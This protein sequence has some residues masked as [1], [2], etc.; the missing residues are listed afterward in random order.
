MHLLGVNWICW[1]RWLLERLSEDHH[2]SIEA[3]TYVSAFKDPV[4]LSVFVYLCQVQGPLQHK[5]YL[6]LPGSRNA[7]RPVFYP[8]HSIDDMFIFTNEVSLA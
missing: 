3:S 6:Y 4:T 2:Q 7:G 5:T 1:S 8:Q